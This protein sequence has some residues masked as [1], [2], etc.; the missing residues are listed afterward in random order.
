[1][2]HLR[3]LHAMASPSGASIMAIYIFDKETLKKKKKGILEL[4]HKNISS[5]GTTGDLCTVVNVAMKNQG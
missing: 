4:P 2:Y 5:D 1:M 3:Y